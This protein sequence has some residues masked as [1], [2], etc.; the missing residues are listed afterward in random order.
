MLS[1]QLRGLRPQAIPESATARYATFAIARSVREPCAFHPEYQA[2]A[3]PIA[4]VL[5]APAR[6]QDRRYQLQARG[7]THLCR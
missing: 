5:L 6:A 3:L 4:V 7:V 2:A 1:G